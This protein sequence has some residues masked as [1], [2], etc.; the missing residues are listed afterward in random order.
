MINCCQLIII[1][2]RHEKLAGPA[3]PSRNHGS[4]KPKSVKRDIIKKFFS[5][6]SPARKSLPVM[7]DKMPEK[8]YIF[9]QYLFE[10]GLHMNGC[11]PDH[12]SAQI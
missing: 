3:P 9:G 1:K 7:S 4:Q 5:C 8:S 11:V 12:L 6:N 2:C 10:C